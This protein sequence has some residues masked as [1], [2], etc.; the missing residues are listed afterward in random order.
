MITYSAF[1]E[2]S[3]LIFK[4]GGIFSSLQG[5]W[6]SGEFKFKVF[7]RLSKFS[8]FLRLC[9]MNGYFLGLLP[10]FSKYIRDLSSLASVIECEYGQ[11]YPYFS[12]NLHSINLNNWGHI[13]IFE[14]GLIRGIV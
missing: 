5:E 2:I 14:A 10:F 4:T 12:V 7:G 3:V 9:I 13:R 11:T 8:D 6:N 1:S